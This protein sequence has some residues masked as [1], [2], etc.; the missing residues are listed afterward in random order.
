MPELSAFEVGMVIKKLKRHK[1]P[2]IDQIQAELFKAGSMTLNSEIHKVSH[3]IWNK[4]EL[5]EECKESIIVPNY[6]KG[7]KTDCGNYRGILLLSN[8]YKVFSNILLSR[9][10]PYAEEIIRD[11]QCRFRRNRSTADFIFCIR[12]ILEMKWE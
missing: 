10:T 1:S 3:S 7:D 12:H 8:T 9:L 5:P 4:E 6:K 11:R 2:G